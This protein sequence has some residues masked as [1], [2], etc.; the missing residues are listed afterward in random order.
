MEHFKDRLRGVR[1]SDNRHAEMLYNEIVESTRRNTG[2]QSPVKPLPEPSPAPAPVVKRRYSDPDLLRR[3]TDAY[4]LFLS[5]ATFITPTSTY[6]ET[7]QLLAKHKEFIEL[8]DEDRRKYYFEKA[9]KRAKL[10]KGTI[11]TG[12]VKEGGEEREEGEV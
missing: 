5:T 1:L 8:E 7:R 3:L 9:L 6:P 2:K 10:S 12:T 4:K 11:D